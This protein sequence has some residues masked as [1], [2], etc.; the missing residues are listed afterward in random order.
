MAHFDANQI[1]LADLIRMQAGSVQYYPVERGNLPAVR[2]HIQTYA[3]RAGGQLTAK[4]LRAF[5]GDDPLY[6]LKV[7]IIKPASPRKPRGRPACRL[8]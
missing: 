7:E 6:L 5:E 3:R 8:P 2:S 1:K 4:T